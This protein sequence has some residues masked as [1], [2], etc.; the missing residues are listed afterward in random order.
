MKN[1]KNT[2]QE[3]TLGEVINFF[4]YQR[5]PLSTVQRKERQGNFPYYGASGIID[6]VNDYIFDGK[7]LLVSEDGE[8]LKTR[9]TPIAFLASGKFWVNNHAHII[10]G[11]EKIADDYFLMSLLEGINILGYLTGTAQ[12]KLSQANLK[13]IQFNLP[14]LSTQQKSAGILSAYD[15][16][17]E[18]N[19]RRI[20]ILEEMA[21]ILYRE[22]FVKF[23]FP[24]HEAVQFVESELGLIPE[25][26]EV[27]TL[28]KYIKTQKGYAFKSSWYQETGVKI[29]KVSNFT[30][31]SIDINNLISIPEDIAEKYKKYQLFLNDIIIQTVGSWAS[32]PQSVVGK[33]IKVPEI[34]SKSLLNQNAVK[35]IPIEPLNNTFLYYILKNDEFKN[36]IINC[37]Q[38]AASQASITLEAIKE[39]KVILPPRKIIDS[40]SNLIIPKWK[41]I[42]NLGLKNINLRKTRDLLLPRLISG[43][44][45]VENLAINTGIQP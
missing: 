9:K 32:N 27:T 22:W 12:P 2:W 33:V 40:F 20:E 6:Y 45:D 11:K 16:L 1:N 24:G 15:D 31:D 19:T 13:A 3:V 42:N 18:N 26:W 37:A 28:G 39:F 41:K 35:I 8:N 21:R 38:G 14:P 17:I 36:Y 44:I 25:G 4:D 5:I 7:Y 34:A 29:V 43:E 10:R 23:R 30:D